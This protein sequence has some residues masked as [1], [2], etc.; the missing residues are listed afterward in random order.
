MTSSKPDFVNAKNNV[1]KDDVTFCTIQIDG[2]VNEKALGSKLKQITGLESSG[3]PA[4]M[5][6]KNGKAVKMHNGGRDANSIAK[7]AKS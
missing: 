3:V 6:F 2:D 1:G 7:F 5:L 4:F